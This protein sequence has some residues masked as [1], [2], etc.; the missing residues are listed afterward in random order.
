[1]VNVEF[2]MFIKCQVT[3]HNKCSKYPPPELM[4]AR[5]LLIM[6]CHTS[7]KQTKR[8]RMAWRASKLHHLSMPSFSIGCEYD[9]GLRVF[10]DKNLKAWGRSDEHGGFTSKNKCLRTYSY[11]D[12]LTI[13]VWGIHYWRL[14]KHFSYIP[15]YVKSS[16]NFKKW[17]PLESLHSFFTLFSNTSE[18]VCSCYLGNVLISALNLKEDMR[19]LACNYLL[20]SREQVILFESSWPKKLVPRAQL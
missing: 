6:D 7:S 12:I 2:L 1:M 17:G 3:I 20:V 18:V 4:D 9:G 19:S 10:S 14:L 15:R 11:M 16:L 8:L 5:T 13:L